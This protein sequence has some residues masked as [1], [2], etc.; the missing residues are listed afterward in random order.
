MDALDAEVS[1]EQYFVLL[2]DPHR[3]AVIANAGRCP[4]PNPALAA[5]SSNQRFFSEGQNQINIQQAE[6]TGGDC[7]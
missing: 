1:S 3:C 4:W 7:C 6:A 5:D 2:G